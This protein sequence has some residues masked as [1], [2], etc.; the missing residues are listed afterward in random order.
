VNGYLNQYSPNF[1]AGGMTRAQ[2]VNLRTNRVKNPAKGI[3]LSID[4]VRTSQVGNR[5]EATFNQI[6]DNQTYKD[7]V[8]KT[9]VFDNVGGKCRIVEEKV[10]KGRLY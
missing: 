5:M 4:N 10:S 1:T 9:L 3:S 7:T 8:E 2:W 6:Y